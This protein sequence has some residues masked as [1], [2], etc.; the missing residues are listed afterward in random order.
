M[1]PCYKCA[2]K[3]L[4]QA[5]HVFTEICQGYAVDPI[6]IADLIGDLGCASGHLFEKQPNL[7]EALRE[8]RVSLLDFFAAN[9][10]KFPNKRP[11]FELYL[12]VVYEFMVE[13]IQNES[14]K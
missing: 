7:S 4:A 10:G 5:R 2:F 14:K 1:T 11:D 6:H 12:R 13:E 9:P 8:D 3:H